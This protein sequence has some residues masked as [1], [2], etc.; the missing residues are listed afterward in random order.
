VRQYG[1]REL[2]RGYIN[3]KKYEMLMI[4]TSEFQHDYLWYSINDIIFR[5]TALL[6][7]PPDVAA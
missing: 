7:N 3:S 6:R 1:G 4:S 5:I 2:E